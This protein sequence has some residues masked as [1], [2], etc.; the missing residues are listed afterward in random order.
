MDIEWSDLEDAV[1]NLAYALVEFPVKCSTIVARCWGL[2]D[3]GSVE[4]IQ[5]DDA[6]LTCHF[7][8]KS[9]RLSLLT[10]QLSLFVNGRQYFGWTVLVARIPRSFSLDGQF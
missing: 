10:Q 1:G 7:L 2:E 3:H 5:D 8:W 4:W 9:E 6:V